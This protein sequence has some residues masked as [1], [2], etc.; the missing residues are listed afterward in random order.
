M[1]V[2]CLDGVCCNLGSAG[3]D[4]AFCP[5]G[6]QMDSRQRKWRARGGSAASPPP[7]SRKW[8]TPATRGQAGG[9]RGTRCSRIGRIWRFTG[10]QPPPHPPGAQA[11][12]VESVHDTERSFRAVKSQKWD[13]RTSTSLFFL[14][15]FSEIHIEM[16]TFLNVKVTFV[17]GK[18]RSPAVI[19]HQQ[20]INIKNILYIWSDLRRRLGSVA[21]WD[22]LNITWYSINILNVSLFL[23]FKNPGLCWQIIGILPWQTYSEPATC[24]AKALRLTVYLLLRKYSSLYSAVAYP[25][26]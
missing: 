5:T 10:L 11:T 16:W 13:W 19:L 21:W 2:C 14:S 1:C 24:R 15:F 22:D 4:D 3:P 6:A 9:N 12:L 25:Y 23:A 17:T 18:I 7:P 20:L 26:N 8:H